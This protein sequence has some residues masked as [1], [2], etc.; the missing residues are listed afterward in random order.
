MNGGIVAFVRLAALPLWLA[1]GIAASVKKAKGIAASIGQRNRRFFQATGIAA[2]GLASG[3]VASV[4]KASGIAALV[5]Q[6]HC[7][8]F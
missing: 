7:R 1:S 6:G 4:Q 3:S 5:A 2:L 8:F